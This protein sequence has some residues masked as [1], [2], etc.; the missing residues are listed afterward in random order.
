MALVREMI[1]G[2]H[3]WPLFVFGDAGAGKTGLALM[4][5]D[6][7]KGEYFTQAEWVRTCR[8]A[9]FGDLR[10]SVGYKLH[11]RDIRKGWEH[12]PVAVLDELGTRMTVS[13]HA[14]ES[15]QWA[16]DARQGLPTVFVSN[17]DLGGLR[18]VFDDRIASRLSAGTV[19]QLSGDHRIKRT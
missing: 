14:Y 8:E 7:A 10:T 11:L 6:W 19:M 15:V 1:A 12:A 2:K 17:L 4:L 16:V 9:E 13:D 3:P 5:V 18:K